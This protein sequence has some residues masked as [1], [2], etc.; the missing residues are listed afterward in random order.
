MLM[1]SSNFILFLTLVHFF[2]VTTGR[3]W[4]EMSTIR[5]IFN[6][7]RYSP[8]EQPSFQEV[9]KPQ[10]ELHID[11]PDSAKVQKTA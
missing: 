6:N 2:H 8:N 7:L 4:F 9:Q 3:K 5:V 11:L 10:L 1:I